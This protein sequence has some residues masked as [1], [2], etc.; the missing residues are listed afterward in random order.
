M[1]TTISTGTLVT[2]VGVEQTVATLTGEGS[3]VLKLDLS[4][5]AVGDTVYIRA[6]EIV[7]SGGTLRLSEEQVLTGVQADGVSN[8]I[9]I[10][11]ATGGTLSFRVLHSAGVSRSIP[12]AVVSL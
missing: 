11:V 5:M 1:S 9:P 4:A 3:Y 7:S 2:T 10:S 6:R 8:T 12:W